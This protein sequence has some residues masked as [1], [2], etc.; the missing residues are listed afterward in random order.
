MF[1]PS[2]SRVISLI[3]APAESRKGGSMGKF[4][5]LKVA[6]AVLALCTAG[7]AQTY[8]AP[9]DPATSFEQ[10]FIQQ[11]NPNGVWSY[12]YSSNFTSPVTVYDETLQNGINGPN[13][14]Y[15]C[16]SSNNIGNSP[17]A[18]YNDGPAY[19]DGNVDFLANQFIL[20]SGI[21]G[22]YSDLV[23]TAPSNATYYIDGNFRGDQY[24]IGVYVGVV[25]NGVV[26]FNSTVTREGEI[27]PFNETVS[28]VAGQTVVFSVGPYNG[29]QNTGLD[30]AIRQS[31][32]NR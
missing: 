32:R 28:L 27:V 14:Q 6:C 2:L 15:W 5:L 9:Y 22:E 7:R 21:G 17:C 26:L 16:S 29:L 1:K 10:G 20:V 25:V 23:F 30:L 3:F 13:A 8:N 11:T 31:P 4:E 19:D 24:G 18:E 12:G